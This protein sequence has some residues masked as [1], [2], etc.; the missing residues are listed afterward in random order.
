MPLT[1][2]L[3]L[4]PD[5]EA[6]LCAEAARRGVSP[7]ECVLEV[8]DATMPDA[9]TPASPAELVDYWEREGVLGIWSDRTD[10]P[11]SPEYARQL[12]QQAEQRTEEQP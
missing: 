9:P 12:R 6:R 7:A 10:M 3:E 5:L 8:L 11:D 2:T 1:L 4:P